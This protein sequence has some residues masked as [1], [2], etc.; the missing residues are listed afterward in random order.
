MKPVSGMCQGIGSKPLCVTL[1]VNYLWERV[2][3][4]V[5][6]DFSGAVKVKV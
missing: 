3:S 6:D 2:G 4:M 5:R 1:R